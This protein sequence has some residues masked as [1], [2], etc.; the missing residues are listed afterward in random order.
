MKLL[1]WYMAVRRAI[2]WSAASAAARR[3]LP[4]LPCGHPYVWS[5]LF[6]GLFSERTA[7]RDLVLPDV[8]VYLLEVEHGSAICGFW[9]TGI[10]LHEHRKRMP[11]LPDSRDPGRDCACPEGLASRQ[12]AAKY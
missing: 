12:P 4:T 8:A 7:P 1:R 9:Q 10:R 11:G 2:A 6:A 3:F 5:L